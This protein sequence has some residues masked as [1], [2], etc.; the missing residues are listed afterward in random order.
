MRSEW[1][2]CAMIFLE[3]RLN[4]EF[5]PIGIFNYRPV[6]GDGLVDAREILVP[7]GKGP[8]T[9]RKPPLLQ[10]ILDQPSEGP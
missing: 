10:Q 2:L 9:T 7:E 5:N 1:P 4:Q 8:V 6:R 3:G